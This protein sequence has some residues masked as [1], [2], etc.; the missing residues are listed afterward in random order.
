[1]IV[2]NCLLRL[3][4]AMVAVT[5]SFIL[6]LSLLGGSAQA[7]EQI[8]YQ[9]VFPA[10]A[11]GTRGSLDFLCLLAEIPQLGM[12][13]STKINGTRGN[14][15]QFCNSNLLAG[16]PADA[17]D[18]AGA[19]RD[20]CRINSSAIVRLSTSGSNSFLYSAYRTDGSSSSNIGYCNNGD[21]LRLGY[22]GRNQ[23]N[24][25]TLYS[26][27][28]LSFSPAQSEYR[29]R[30]L[31]IGSGATV[32]LSS[33]DYWI[34]SLNINGNGHLRI[35]GTARVFVNQGAMNDGLIDKGDASALTLVSYNDFSMN[36]ASRLEG[37]VYTNNRL[38]MNGS[39]VI[40]GRVTVG[41]LSMTGSSVINDA[42]RFTLPNLTCFTDNFS[43]SSLPNWVV[44][45]SSGNFSPSTT[46]QGRL[47]MTQA[48]SN[49]AT[50]ATY[51][52]LFPGAANYITVEFNHY[53]YDGNGADGMA[54]VLSDA[55]FTPRPGAFGGPLGYGYKPGIAGFAGGWLGVGLDEYGNYSSEGG[56]Y[57]YA[58][59]L[60]QTVAVRGSGR[61]TAGYNFLAAVCDTST[62]SYILFG[63]CMSPSIDGNNNANHQYRLTL[64]SRNSGR[65]IL[66]IERNT[67]SG[68]STIVDNFNVLNRAGQL[69]LPQNLLFSLTG[70]TGQN[71]NVHEIDN[72]RICALK[73]TAITG[74]I[75]HFEIEINDSPL[76]CTPLSMTLKACK[77]ASCSELY[78]DAVTAT[79]APEAG[80]W[81]PNNPVSFSGGSTTIQL[82]HT[83]AGPVTLDVTGSAPV[84]KAFSTTLCR[85]NGGALSN[86]ACTVNFSDSGFVFDVPDKLA[87]K[88][89]DVLIKAV[90]KDDITKRCVSAFASTP[91]NL[92]FWSSVVDRPSIAGYTPPP[93][94]VDSRAIAT[95][96]ASASAQVVQFNAQGEASVKV[97][98]DDAGKLALHAQYIGSGIDAGLV[99][100]G[101]DA[102]VSFPVGLC[103]T[104]PE[105]NADCA[106]GSASCSA[107][108][109]AGDPFTLNIRAKRWQN[110][111]DSN[112]CSNGDTP[113]FAMNAV[114][115]SHQLVAPQNGQLGE[116]AQRD[117]AQLASV[118]GTNV[119]QSVSEV[120]V[121][122]FGA[123]VQSPYLGSQ[124]FTIPAYLSDAVGRFYPAGF[125]A[126]NTSLTPGCGAFT[127]M[128]Q[129]FFLSTNLRAL[130]RGGQLT[131]NY[132]G[133]FADGVARLQAANNLD[134]IDLS[135]RLSALAGQ[136]NNGQM[137]FSQAPVT[138]SRPPAPQAD[139]PYSALALGVRID[140]RDLVPMANADMRADA[141][142]SCTG[143]CNAQRLS[144]LDVRQ[145]R[146]VLANTYGPENQAI[147]MAG[148]SQYW[149][150]QQ[151]RLN[152]DDSCSVVD[153]QMLS[154]V[155]N[156]NMGYSFEPEMHT[157]QGITRSAAPAAVNQGE[158][159]IRWQSSGTY[160]GKVTA[161][162]VLPDY[163]EWY[164]N[165]DTQSNQLEPPRGSVYFGRYR[166]NDRIINWRELP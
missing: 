17:C 71:N 68:Y 80:P 77:N 152:T 9:N 75:D 62:L 88:P 159:G 166:G 87:A 124:A 118:S 76:T 24:S 50:S 67:G 84:T 144:T 89:I 150:G 116:L 60:R 86:A 96:A 104:A 27:C 2:N 123:S 97:N 7:F 13:N 103:V 85:Q 49:Q 143:S 130:N 110:D 20:Y 120:G 158:F 22:D 137:S 91:K 43:S 70:S 139:G 109:A 59:I 23:F 1:M 29:L 25:V 54:L 82:S 58:G 37:Y 45:R 63:T 92:K 79:L 14:R 64:D 10:V 148:A 55:A 131:Q 138:F 127:Y 31:S 32:T 6:L 34:E 3:R 122:Q 66:K 18:T 69:A 11:Q 15:L 125:I 145:G 83:Q 72:M 4:S 30:S 36:G 40:E 157:P 147:M 162:I 81:L 28:D 117:Y 111:N 90:K 161:P 155:S 114:A 102:F 12:Y 57:N 135:A 74:V 48:V 94:T 140:D 112:I 35:E 136:W 133:S 38:Y 142:G 33:G 163:L 98:Y 107:F 8:N 46:P 73:S 19:N 56:D 119:Q 164:W 44:A 100:E 146:A 93:V 53:A 39:S 42:D 105:P 65:A 106:S 156:N 149:D 51:Q 16:M 128:D 121:F 21:T 141:V 95:A 26:N 41:L 134:G 154:L 160:R 61:G 151:W 126:E 101:N 108:R 47:R 99:M 52:R 5:G 113:S 165:Y 78:T 153:G 132:T 129:P 115:L